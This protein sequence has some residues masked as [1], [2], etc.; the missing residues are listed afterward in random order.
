M[1]STASRLVDTQQ[2]GISQNGRVIA[3]DQQ[4][5]RSG[6]GTYLIP[7]SRQGRRNVTRT[8]KDD[9]V[10]ARQNSSQATRTSKHARTAAAGSDRQCARAATDAIGRA[11]IQH[12]GAAGATEHDA[13]RARQ[14]NRA[15]C[16]QPKLRARRATGSNTREHAGSSGK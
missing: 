13:L 15:R 12:T 9:V 14:G 10:V 4:V 8:T 3:R 1:Q 11:G 16:G 6:P 2:A 5:G 7:G